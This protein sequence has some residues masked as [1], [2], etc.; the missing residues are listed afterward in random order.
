MM[1]WMNINRYQRVVKKHFGDRY[2]DDILDAA[3]LP[4]KVSTI[5]DMVRE[6]YKGRYVVSLARVY[7]L[8]L[9][10]QN[11]DLILLRLL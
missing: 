8:Q 6:G 10:I 9:M 5:M 4:D 11:K 1:R 2:I 7:A 3:G